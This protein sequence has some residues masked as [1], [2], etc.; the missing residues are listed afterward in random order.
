M[1]P[2]GCAHAASRAPLLSLRRRS[3]DQVLKTDLGAEQA[4]GTGTTEAAEGIMFLTM[5]LDRAIQHTWF[6]AECECQ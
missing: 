3:A 2:T 1:P 4:E 5:I 6:A